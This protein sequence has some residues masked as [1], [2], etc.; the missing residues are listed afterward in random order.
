MNIK[1]TPTASYP[2]PFRTASAGLQRPNLLEKLANRPKVA[3][4]PKAYGNHSEE[5]DA[6]LSGMTRTL[7]RRISGLNLPVGNG[8]DTVQRRAA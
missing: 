4:A 3:D 8:M 1:P 5:Q 6:V 2:R 7:H